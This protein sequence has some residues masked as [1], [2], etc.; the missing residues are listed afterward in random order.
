MSTRPRGEAGQVSAVL[1]RSATERRGGRW[2]GPLNEIGI[3]FPSMEPVVDRMQ[4]AFFRNAGAVGLDRMFEL[5]VAPDEIGRSVEIVLAVPYRIACESCG[6]RGESWQRW[7]DACGSSG[8]TDIRQ[9]V[10][11]VLPRRATDGTRFVL[12]VLDAELPE[13]DVRIRVARS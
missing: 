13:V 6:G 11:V 12:R 5:V 9:R 3:D 8:E 1:V 4:S 10:R 7:C 2:F